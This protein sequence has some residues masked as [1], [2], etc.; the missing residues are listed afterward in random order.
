MNQKDKNNFPRERILNEAEILF[1]QKGYHAVSVREIT[2]TAQCNLAAVNYHF[3]NKENL[4]LEVFR[5]RW[6]PRA[7]RIIDCFERTSASQDSFSPR[8]MIQALAQAFLEGPLSDEERQRHFL[9][10]AREMAQPTRALKMVAEQVMGPFFQKLAD[11]L[12]VFMPEELSEER[13][14]LNILSIFAVV[15]YFNFARMAVTRITGREY[16]PDFKAQLMEQ[17]I[18]FSLKGLGGIEKGEI[19]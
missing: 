17:I 15:L 4:Y 1:A 13:L 14:K 16:D 12:S 3:G 7:R 11:K 8:A 6:M 18:Q 19:G 5:A 2:N 10:M 9:L